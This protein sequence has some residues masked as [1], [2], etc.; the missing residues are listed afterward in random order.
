MNFGTRIAFKLVMKRKMDK[1]KA[2]KRPGVIEIPAQR[3]DTKPIDA[4]TD[5]VL[6]RVEHSASSTQIWQNYSECRMQHFAW[7]R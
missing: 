5:D 4:G 3:P 6:L 7:G 1:K 2:H